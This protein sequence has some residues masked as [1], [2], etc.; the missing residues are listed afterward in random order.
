[1]P[2]MKLGRVVLGGIAAGVVIDL[3]EGVMRG[4]LL[5]ERA[6]D[7]MAELGRT[8]ALS[9]KQIVALE[10][11]GLVVGICTVLLYAAIRPRLGAGPKTAILAGLF[12][13]ALVFALGIMPLV[14][15]HLLPV[16][17]GVITVCGEA[18]MMILAGLAGAALYN[19]PSEPRE[20]GE[21]QSS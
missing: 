7:A 2:K 19:D 1:M 15:M 18:A 20:A 21:S 12:I 5:Q 4:I 16:C 14:F 17:L 8:A 3:W 6:A 10:V 9:M 11:W 13:W